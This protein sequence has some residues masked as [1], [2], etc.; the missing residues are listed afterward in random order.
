MRALFDDISFRFFREAIAALI[1]PEDPQS[2]LIAEALCHAVN[3]GCL[4]VGPIETYNQIQRRTFSTVFEASPNEP[5]LWLAL[6]EDW[7][8]EKY[9]RQASSYENPTRDDLQFNGYDVL[10]MPK[11]TTSGGCYASDHNMLYLLIEV[12]LKLCSSN[13][14]DSGT[15]RWLEEVGSSTT[16][17]SQ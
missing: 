12:A 11:I 6:A 2:L 10:N 4:K 3:F 16:G 14:G 1:T 8:N 9:Q 15:T 7:T 13:L 17:H 5:P